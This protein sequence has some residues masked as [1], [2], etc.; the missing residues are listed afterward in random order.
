[1][2]PNDLVTLGTAYAAHKGYTLST[3]STYAAQS[4]SFLGRL[5]AGKWC[6]I[7]TYNRA[8]NWFVEN[9][10]DDLQWPAGIPRPADQ[11]RSARDKSRGAA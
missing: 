7:N 9:W 3:V 6:H 11:K 2:N 10:P 4:G 5:Q 1:M 8:L